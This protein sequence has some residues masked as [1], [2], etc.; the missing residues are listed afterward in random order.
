MWS[1]KEIGNFGVRKEHSATEKRYIRVTNITALISVLFMLMWTILSLFIAHHIAATLINGAGAVLFWM[2]IL[3]NKRGFKLLAATWFLT[4]ACLQTMYHL[5][6]FG[7]DSGIEL[8]FILIISSTYVTIPR[9][10]R[11]VS[12]IFSGAICLLWIIVV[13]YADSIFPHIQGNYLIP[14]DLHYL[15]NVLLVS[16]TAALFLFTLSKAIDN[17]EL[18]LKEEMDKSDKL[19]N[20]ILPKSIAER[21]KNNPSTIADSYGSVTVL[22]ADIVG[23]TKFSETVPPNEL[24][25]KLNVMFTE[26]DRMTEKYGLEKIKTI[27]DAYMVSGGLPDH[28]SD[29]VLRVVK[30]ANSMLRYMRDRQKSSSDNLQIRIGIHTGPAVAGVIGLRKFAYDLWGDTVN[31]ASRMESHG[32]A[33]KIHVTQEIRDALNADYEFEKREKINVKSKGF[34]QTYFLIE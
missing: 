33:G 23:F 12:H 29:H 5:Y 15:I 1:I 27:G 2:T 25:D 10:N 16:F 26:F 13:L 21:L 14:E 28:S 32:E 11:Y 19:L 8:I 7:C 22:F 18:S 17:S 24:V 34:M 9:D 30:M 3:I 20:N 4:I 6:L 31:V